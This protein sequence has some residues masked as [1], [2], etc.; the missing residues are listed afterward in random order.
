MT[1][2]SYAKFLNAIVISFSLLYWKPAF[3]SRNVDIS[4]VGDTKTVVEEANNTTSFKA[5]TYFLIIINILILFLCVIY[6]AL[7]FSWQWLLQYQDRAILKWVKYQKLR[8]F[9]EPYHA[10]Y[11]GKYRYW[12][13]LLLFVRAFLYTISVANFS[14]D[15]R[16]DLVSVILV[17][18][19]LILLKGVIAKRVYKNWPLDVMETVIYFNLVAFSALT[20]YNLEGRGNQVAAAYISVVIIFILLLGVIMFHILR[21]TRLYTCTFVEKAFKWTSFKLV[22]KRPRQVPPDNAPEE[23]D[24]FRFERSVAG[25]QQLPAVTYSEVEI[26]QTDQNP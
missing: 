17:V 10:P 5:I 21:Y 11:N 22:D 4:V 8:H 23:L 6:I 24:G 9:L 19:G 1:L 7:V 18:G 25:D 3:G 15:P 20:L 2:L 14:L 26:S 16:V 13:G 12:T